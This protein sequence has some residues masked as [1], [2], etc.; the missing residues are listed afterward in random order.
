MPAVRAHLLELSGDSAGA[1]QSYVAAASLAT[2][3]PQRRYLNA[4][5]A[6]LTS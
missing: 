4:R 3:L 1:Q 2:S 6:R 5:A